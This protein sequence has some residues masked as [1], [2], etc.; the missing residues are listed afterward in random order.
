MRNVCVLAMCVGAAWS[1]SL[2]AQQATKPV[3]QAAAN[4]GALDRAREAWAKVKHVEYRANVENYVGGR[5]TGTY[6]AK[7][8]LERSGSSWKMAVDGELKSA[9]ASK[10]AKPRVVKVAFDGAKAKSIVPTQKQVA[11]LDS[12]AWEDVSAFFMDQQANR[13]ILWELLGDKPL[14]LPDGA[15]VIAEPATKIGEESMDVVR[16][17]LTGKDKPAGA[18]AGDSFGGRYTIDKNGMI[19]KVERLRPNVTGDN[20]NAKP[21]RVITIEDVKLSDEL[22]PD[23]FALATPEGY[24][25]KVDKP[26]TALKAMED[27]KKDVQKAPA[28]GDDDYTKGLLAVGAEAPG[29]SLKTADSKPISLAELKGKVVVLDFWATW[30]GPCKMAIPSLQKVADKYKDTGNVVVLGMLT[31]DDVSLAKKILKEKNATYT[32]VTNAE[33]TGGKYKVSAIPC[34]Y[35]VGPDGKIAAR[36]VG[37]AES[38]PEDLAKVIDPL[39]K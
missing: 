19:R 35:V 36:H 32:L 20:A 24:T 9:A 26:R 34:L 15:N 39:V 5:L 25:V 33:S 27:A 11:E 23:T 28:A 37:F 17:V 10:D 29:F 8:V 2:V 3:G 30:C 31:D 4:A 18:D 13:A 21:L 38:L 22:K 14:M 1:V 12:S 6:T 7:V 16:V